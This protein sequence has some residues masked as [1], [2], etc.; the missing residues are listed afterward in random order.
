MKSPA[1]DESVPDVI[2]PRLC[3]CSKPEKLGASGWWSEG[4]CSTLGVRTGPSDFGRPSMYGEDSTRGARTGMDILSPG[5]PD[6][7]AE[8]CDMDF[9]ADVAGEWPDQD[10]D[11][12]PCECDESDVSAGMTD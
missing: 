3:A 5:P 7:L 4:G 11:D 1:F 2:E 10:G 6:P 9:V 8:V 12:G